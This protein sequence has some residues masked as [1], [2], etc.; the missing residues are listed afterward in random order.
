M[1]NRSKVDNKNDF[2][3]V[4]VDFR[5]SSIPDSG[6]FRHIMLSCGVVTQDKPATLASLVAAFQQDVALFESRTSVEAL[7]HLM[8]RELEATRDEAVMIPQRRLRRPAKG[9][10][11][12]FFFFFFFCYLD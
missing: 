4:S 1:R 3:F 10:S 8:A 2:F 11:S 12:L 7:S 9:W 5:T 6:F